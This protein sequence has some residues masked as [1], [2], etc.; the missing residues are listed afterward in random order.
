MTVNGLTRRALVAGG[1]ALA[2]TPALARRMSAGERVTN[3]LIRQRADAQIALQADGLYT[4]MASVPEYD[5][6][7]LR[8]A[9]TIAGL[10]TAPET[11]LWRR[12]AT[13]KMAGH[14][15]APEIHQID[16]RWYVYVA[17]GDGGD[18]FHIRTYV[19]QCDGSDPVKGRWS[20]LGQLQTP[21]DTFTLDST[22]F[23]H[24][25][26]R[27]LAWAQKEPGIDTNSNL[28][29]A[30]LA[31]PTTLAAKPARLTVPT[32]PW[33]VQGFKVAEGPAPLIRNG[34]IF[35]TYSASATDARYCM[36]MLTA[37]DDADLM[38]PAA[39]TKSPEPVFRTVPER[40][41]Y[42][43]GH[44]SFTVDRAGRDVLVYHARDYE[45]ITGDPLYDPNRDTRVQ[46]F[47]YRADGTP[48]FG[49]PL[50]NGPTMI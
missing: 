3:P 45:K 5:R 25:G 50:A 1:A 33:E 17:A 48:D 46:R 14:I 41:I 11:V 37:R 27:Y 23:V 26:T 38:D 29:L 43:P 32:L 6:V 9:A 8:R 2:V 7:V 4:F 19:L 35:M 21:W 49:L 40:R 44:N 28:Y 22:T 42:G 18:V 34:R 31:T 24:R 47:G 15:W 30:P 20:V 36:G 12:P 39:W 16:G 10:A 13:G